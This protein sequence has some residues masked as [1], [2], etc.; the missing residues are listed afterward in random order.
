MKTER[1]MPYLM[2]Q[3]LN[4]KD[5]QEVSASGTSRAT[6]EYTFLPGSGSD[7]CYDVESDV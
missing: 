2:A 5:L 6:F 4:E 3:K 7:V 1:I